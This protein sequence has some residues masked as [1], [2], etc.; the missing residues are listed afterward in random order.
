M[1]NILYDKVPS[2]QPFIRFQFQRLKD[3]LRVRGI[4]SQLKLTR[5]SL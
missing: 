2:D 3:S 4:Q 1:M 5:P